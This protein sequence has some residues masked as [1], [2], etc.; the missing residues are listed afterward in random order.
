MEKINIDFLIEQGKS[1]RSGLKYI[2]PPS[3]TWRTFKVYQLEDERKYHT[4]AS[5]C[6]RFLNITYPNDSCSSS[7]AKAAEDFEGK[8]NHF[9]PQPLDKM[10]GILFYKF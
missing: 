10:I 9:C 3:G 8:A 6:I 2:S 7:F 1:I 5:I 4:W